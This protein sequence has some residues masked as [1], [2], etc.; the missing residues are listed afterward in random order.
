MLRG[1]RSHRTDFWKGLRRGVP[2][3]VPVGGGSG[4]GVPGNGFP[5]RRFSKGELF[6]L[7]NSK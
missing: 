5:E 2:E 3:G 7:E 4:N 1:G 6:G